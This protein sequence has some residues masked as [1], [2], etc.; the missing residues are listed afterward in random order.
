MNSGTD[1]GCRKIDIVL[2]RFRIV[3]CDVIGIEAA[4]ASGVPAEGPLYVVFAR[5]GSEDSERCNRHG[6][7]VLVLDN[8]SGNDLN[9][10][11]CAIPRST[12]ECRRIRAGDQNRD[13]E[14]VALIASGFGRW[15]KL[16]EVEVLSHLLRP[17]RRAALA[18]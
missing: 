7:L 15:L 13:F 18:A 9:V 8:G 4:E 6:S 10:I 5:A 17:V 11:A 16:A 14:T 3:G 1:S 2:F 12:G